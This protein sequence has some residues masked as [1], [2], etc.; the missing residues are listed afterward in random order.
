MPKERRVKNPRLPRGTTK[1]QTRQQSKSP[2]AA[3]HQREEQK[4]SSRVGL[5]S[6]GHV[7]AREGADSVCPTK[8][9]RQSEQEAS[10][11]AAEVT[12]DRLCQPL[13]KQTLRPL[14]KR[15]FIQAMS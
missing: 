1:R 12:R 15:A 3:Q 14:Q 6:N 8:N 13:C 11:E 10:S 4:A 5:I 9:K 7:K 2:A